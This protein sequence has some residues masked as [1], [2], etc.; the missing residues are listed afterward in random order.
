MQ[1]GIVV[2]PKSIHRERTEQNFNIWDFSLTD[3]EMELIA[4]FDIGHSEIVN[5]FD[6]NFVRALHGR[7]A[8]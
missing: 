7:F 8:R 3:E 6:P 5:H 2:I 1:R 4:S